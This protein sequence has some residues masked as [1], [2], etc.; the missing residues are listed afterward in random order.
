[1][2]VENQKRG[3]G[4]IAAIILNSPGSGNNNPGAVLLRRCRPGSRQSEEKLLS[5]ALDDLQVKG[6]CQLGL[7]DG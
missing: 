5:A 3:L 4:D 7:S 2:P 1:M 6:I